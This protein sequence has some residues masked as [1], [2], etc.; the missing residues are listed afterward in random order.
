M[1]PED[2]QTILIHVRFWK[3]I[4]CSKSSFFQE[5]CSSGQQKCSLEHLARTFPPIMRKKLLHRP[6]NDMIFLKGIF[7]RTKHPL[8]TSEVFTKVQPKTFRS[9]SEKSSAIFFETTVFPQKTLLAYN[10]KFWQLCW[11]FSPNFKTMSL[12]IRKH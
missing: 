11:N 7:F 6:K 5:S 8:E 4:N 1:L 10:M 12:K 2:F 3:K 9:Q